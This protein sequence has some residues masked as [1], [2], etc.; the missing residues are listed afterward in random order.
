MQ[1]VVLPEEKTRKVSFYLAMEEYVARNVQGGDYL[2]C[3]QVTPSVI[4]G[5][6][7][8]I[9]NEVNLDYCRQHDIS[10]FRRKSGGGC[11]YADNDNVMF[12]FITA[13]DNV[14]VAF[15]R[16]IG[17]MV[18][19]LKRLGADASASGRNDIMVDGKK[20]SGNAFY[21]LP[22][23]SIVHGTMLYDTDMD[24]ML[25]SITPT[26]DKLQSKGVD[27]VRQRIALLKDYLDLD[28]DEFKSYIRKGL[29]SGE[30]VL[31]ETDVK[32]I[33]DIERR[34][35]LT[36][37][38]ILG[39]NPRYTLTK[40]CRIEGTGSLE[41]HIEMKGETIRK[42]ELIGD[43]FAIGDVNSSILRRLENVRLDR[44]DISNALPEKLDDI[45][46]NLKKDDFVS[47]LTDENF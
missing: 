28:I 40:R 39:N 10:L 7:Q 33:E 41:A 46:M 34:V 37:D 43:F 42:V 32:E 20:V 22:G 47:L 35:Y 12:S 36:R 1:Y 30:Y 16:Y 4:V 23:R 5:R 9:A 25:Q 18:L 21:H 45:I 15:S 2:F 6:N 44:T 17:A 26:T 27:S 3:W 14:G 19:M 13:D 11:V 8:L 29:C 24:N 31:T 38:F